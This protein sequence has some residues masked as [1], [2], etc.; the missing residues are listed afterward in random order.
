MTLNIPLGKGYYLRSDNNQYILTHFDGKR[1][2]H[3]AYCVSIESAINSY[4]DKRVRAFDSTSIHSLL[5][6]IK[7][8]QTSLNKALRPLNLEIKQIGGNDE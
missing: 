5:E 8:L 4:I 1:D 6:S 2:N 7:S 3:V